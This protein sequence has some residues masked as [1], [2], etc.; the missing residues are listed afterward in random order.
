ME[1]NLRRNHTRY[2]EIEPHRPNDI[3]ESFSHF[4]RRKYLPTQRKEKKRI[5]RNES[6]KCRI[7]IASVKCIGSNENE[8]Y[9]AQKDETKDEEIKN[10]K[11]YQFKH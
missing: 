7:L 10:W 9:F 4:S 6:H 8:T 1:F 11:Y 2:Q 5:Q 3:R